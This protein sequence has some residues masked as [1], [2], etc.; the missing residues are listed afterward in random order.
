MNL[1]S[2]V[3]DRNRSGDDRAGQG[4]PAGFVKA[5]HERITAFS[6]LVFKNKKG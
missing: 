4:A 1:E 2:G 5:Y 6:G 3:P